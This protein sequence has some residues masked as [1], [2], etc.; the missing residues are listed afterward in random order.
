[1]ALQE[2]EKFAAWAK[3]HVL[4][5]A[6]K[7]TIELKEKADA[8]LEPHITELKA[9]V[10]PHVEAFLEKIEP[11]IEQSKV[12]LKE[13][14]EKSLE[15]WSFTEPKLMEV[16]EQLQPYADAAAEKLCELTHVAKGHVDNHTGLI[17]QK[18]MVFIQEKKQES[19]QWM[20]MQQMAIGKALNLQTK[21]TQQVW[22]GAVAG[23]AHAHKSANE[24][25]AV[26]EKESLAADLKAKHLKNED[27]TAASIALEA[28]N[29]LKAL[30]DK[31]EAS[32]L[33]KVDALNQEDYATAQAER[34]VLDEIAM[35]ADAC[36]KTVPAPRAGKPSEAGLAES[37]AKS[38]VTN[39]IAVNDAKMATV[40]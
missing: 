20:T 9:K 5:P 32:I 4:E 16:K 30:G 28:Q 33:A 7:K 21:L 6:G 39:A 1:V 15:C 27:Y 40:D 17:K 36:V 10:Q 8:A 37:V 35:E 38:A 11:Q 12:L 31:A 14:Q 25:K 34:K 3:E 29:K 26:R 13:V 19:E 18:S 24:L 2:W 23:A 22:D